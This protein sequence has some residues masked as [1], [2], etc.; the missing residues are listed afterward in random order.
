[1]HTPRQP[2]TDN[3]HFW[4]CPMCPRSQPPD[5]VYNAGRTHI[6]VCHQHRI[7]W[8]LGANLFSSWKDE[9]EQQQR[10]RYREIEDYRRV[11]AVAATW[12]SSEQAQGNAAPAPEDEPC[13]F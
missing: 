1:M 11:D 10:E 13:L 7:G 6:G 9:T 12:N 8:R 3:A 5:D 2:E 4:G